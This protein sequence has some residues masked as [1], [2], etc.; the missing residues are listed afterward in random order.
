MNSATYLISECTFTINLD[1]I[2]LNEFIGARRNNSSFHIEYKNTLEKTVRKV[3]INIYSRA[4]S[5]QDFSDSD[6]KHHLARFS[7]DNFY[8]TENE[9]LVEIYICP[10]S[11]RTIWK[12]VMNPEGFEQVL[13]GKTKIIIKKSEG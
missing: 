3:P 9:D 8:L 5:P 6:R 4:Q 11:Y 13:G 1:E 10:Y 7:S 12:R 2:T